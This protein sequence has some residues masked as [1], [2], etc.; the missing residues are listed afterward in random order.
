MA[1]SPRMPIQ[2]PQPPTAERPAR[3]GMMGGKSSADMISTQGP[4][5]GL[6]AGRPAPGGLMGG[7]AAG[8]G[9]AA[10]GMSTQGPMDGLA[11]GRPAQGGLMGGKAAGMMGGKAAGMAAPTGG[12]STQGPM[13][14]LAA[15]GVSGFAKGGK[16]R[17]MKSAQRSG[18]GFKGTF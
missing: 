12:I 8:M 4:M 13:D 11:A 5:D 15:S 2:R 16:V 6:A 1:M 9:P 10:G 7:K 17:G 3:G 18:K 14:G